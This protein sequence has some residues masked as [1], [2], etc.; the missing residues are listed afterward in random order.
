MMDVIHVD[1]EILART[2][3]L[4]RQAGDSMAESQ[5]RLKQLSLTEE[6]GGLLDLHLGSIRIA[7]AGNAVSLNGTVA[8]VIPHL[9][10]GIASVQERMSALSA[11]LL[12]VV[13]HFSELENHLAN[14]VQEANA[15]SQGKDGA[16]AA[17]EELA[18]HCLDALVRLL[19]QVNPPNTLLGWQMVHEKGF[20]TDLA[21]SLWALLN[22]DLQNAFLSP[23][24]KRQFLFKKALDALKPSTSVQL[25]K[26]EKV[27]IDFEKDSHSFV[28]ALEIDHLL[29]ASQKNHKDGISYEAEFF[30]DLFTAYNQDKDDNAISK[31]L[32]DIGLSD[33][34]T[35][36]TLEKM[37]F[38]KDLS[39]VTKVIDGM[40]TAYTVTNN[41]TS[42]WNQL[43]IVNSLDS[44]KLLDMA[45]IYKSSGDSAMQNVGETF[46]A[47]AKADEAQRI[48]M[49]ASGD[50][51]DMGLDYVC[52]T[53]LK[54]AVGSTN[55]YVEVA[56]LTA[57][58][59]DIFMG[60]N[61]APQLTNELVFAS[62]A[63]EATYQVLQADIAA[64]EANPTDANLQA[65]VASYSAYC[66]AAASVSE[67]C[68]AFYQNKADHWISNLV[69]SDEARGAIDDCNQSVKNLDIRVDAAERY[70]HDYQQYHQ[71]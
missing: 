16:S 41:V 17:N 22:M 32:H 40:S 63:A 27:P 24:K 70:W 29:T 46:E 31:I 61:D 4:L 65:A 36:Q 35:A 62:D 37:K 13:S 1:E 69:M 10:G 18:A 52:D 15:D 30:D 3:D 45:R 7:C 33:Q 56:Q 12:S 55:P 20:I 54:Q 26:I 58:T 59:A 6:S 5:N 8:D 51:V 28:K 48:L 53:A 25:A 47:L 38:L 9:S 2:A 57:T 60:V 39:K 14:S 50:L 49:I 67:A 44:N 23:V 34:D 66:K 68:G 71:A 21:N 43:Q 64:Y 19:K 11:A 42:I